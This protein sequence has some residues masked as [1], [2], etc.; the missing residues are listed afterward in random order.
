M[1]GA[2]ESPAAE[3]D[4]HRGGR[5]FT[6]GQQSARGVG[7]G[8][9]Y[10]LRRGEGGGGR[11]G[12]RKACGGGHRAHSHGGGGGE[13]PWRWSEV[14][15]AG[16]GVMVVV[17]ASAWCGRR[18][19]RIVAAGHE[20]QT[21]RPLRSWPQRHRRRLRVGGEFVPPPHDN[22][23]IESSDHDSVR[24]HGRSGACPLPWRRQAPPTE[25]ATGVVTGDRP[26]R[27]PGAS[28]TS[29]L[30]AAAASAADGEVVS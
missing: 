4:G 30:T 13:G 26:M 5:R 19:Q 9:V 20:R 3:H 17:V 2:A 18:H 7:G 14:P 6:R 23:G 1:E 21:R 11:K 10:G 25:T 24:A 27:A 29:T 28:S 12:N 15:V 16:A 8:K 22:G